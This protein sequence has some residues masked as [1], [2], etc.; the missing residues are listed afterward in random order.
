MNIE[1]TFKDNLFRCIIRSIQVIHLLNTIC[2]Y[3]CNIVFK[4]TSKD[5]PEMT[6]FITDLRHI[7]QPN[8]SIIRNFKEDFIW[9][10]KKFL[11]QQYF[12]YHGSLTTSPFTE[13]VVWIVFPRPF[14]ISKKQVKTQ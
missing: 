7:I 10:K 3:I 8:S 12:T 9:L 13:C 11:K 1:L 6:N 14:K 2:Y 4:A 5:N